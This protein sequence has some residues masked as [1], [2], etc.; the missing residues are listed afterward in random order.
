MSDRETGPY[1][2]T[3][4]GR[5]VNPFEPDPAAIDV[6]DIA[7][8]LSKLCRFG[9]HCRVFYSVA[10]HSC[11]V[12]DAVARRT[13]EP[14]VVLYALLHDA[15]EA[16]LGDVPHPIKHR[17]ELGALYRAAE[18]RLHEAI[19]ARFSL[20][21]EADPLVGEIDRAV[22]AAERRVLMA[23]VWPWPELEGVGPADVEIEPWQPE[24]AAQEF[25]ARYE[26]LT[27]SRTS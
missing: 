11:L 26:R 23:D 14:G 24:R 8:A 15:S 19:C 17:S 9:G 4:S 6:A 3:Q 25:L 10:Q 2:Q 16:Y 12:A 20:A 18:A 13:D 21:A 22:L 1:I 7:G 27:S 5:R